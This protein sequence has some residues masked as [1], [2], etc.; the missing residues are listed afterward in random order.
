M[1]DCT[2][3]FRMINGV[4]WDVWDKGGWIIEELSFK[5]LKLERFVR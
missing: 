1:F 2:K 5:L 3:G 4:V